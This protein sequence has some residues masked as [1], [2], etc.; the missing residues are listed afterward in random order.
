MIWFLSYLL[1]LYPCKSTRVRY[2]VKTISFCWHLQIV[3]GA[4]VPP[5][6]QLVR[7]R[8]IAACV[9]AAHLPSAAHAVA[10]LSWSSPAFKFSRNF[11]GPSFS[12]A[13]EDGECQNGSFCIGDCLYEISLVFINCDNCDSALTAKCSRHECIY[14]G[15]NIDQTFICSTIWITICSKVIIEFFAQWCHKCLSWV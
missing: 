3:E 9:H 1:S 6:K 15:S 2:S 5:E 4:T 13:E 8:K 7:P 10:H 11:N 12:P 14:I